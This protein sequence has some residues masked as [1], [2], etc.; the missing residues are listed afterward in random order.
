MSYAKTVGVG[1]GGKCRVYYSEKYKRKVIEKTVG[2]N[3]LR[4]K[5]A[6]RARL[7]TLLRNYSHNE[8]SLKKEMVF[9]MLTKI[10]ALDC[11]VEV[12]GYSSN[13]FK[14]I[15]EYCEGGD[16][17]KV[18]DTY[19]IPIQDKMTMISQ[20]LLAI[21]EI[22]EVGFIHG[23]LKCANIF[24]VNKYIPRDIKNIRIK[25]GDFG[26]S[27]IGGDL[28]YGGTPGFMAPEVPKY[29]GSF[30]AD[31]YSIGK[32]MLEIMTE[33]PVQ[34]IAAINI[35]SLY[36]IKDKLPKFLNVSEF[37][38]VVIPCLCPDFTKRPNAKELFELY[39]GLMAYWVICEEINDKILENY[40]LGDKVPVDSHEHILTLSNDHMRGYNGGKWYCDSCGNEKKLFLS[41]TLSFN[42]PNCKYDLCQKCISKHDYKY[43][44]NNMLQH[45]PK[46]K[47]AYVTTHEHYL[48]LCSKEE[49][50]YREGWRC[51]ICK[52]S[53][54]KYIDS[55]HCK[56]CQ[57]DLCLKCYEKYF[58]IKEE[59]CCCLIY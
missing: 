12:L 36:T 52:A 26:L 21:K 56:K 19:E 13:P 4:T 39:H 2:P 11:C 41:N 38:N 5:D 48:L 18:L 14:I 40:K 45:V 29:G 51:D 35:N 20:I 32:V 59:K 44:N 15:M 27:E 23:D 49:R 53:F 54:C 57:Y 3:F 47:K 28:V 24:L 31:I 1:G 37:Y 58:K 25:I 34:I 17:R 16:L 10:A 42:C 50:I 6:N 55:F 8:D 43:V 46:G 22:H 9:M 30:E 33:L 7:T